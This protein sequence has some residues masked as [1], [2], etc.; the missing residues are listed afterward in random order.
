MCLASTKVVICQLLSVCILSWIQDGHITEA[1]DLG[2]ALLVQVAQLT[3]DAL[4]VQY[5]T[6]VFSR[7]CTAIAGLDL[8]WR[9][10]VINVLCQSICTI[11]VSQL[12]L[13]AFCSPARSSYSVLL[14]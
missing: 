2:S 5:I 13:Q 9:T 10:L 12:I 1:V 4:L 8:S 11:V 14:D 6:A 7:L 3:D